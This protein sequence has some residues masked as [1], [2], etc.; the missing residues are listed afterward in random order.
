MQ[1]SY[2]KKGTLGAW[3]LPN[4]EMSLGSDCASPFELQLP[5]GREAFDPVASL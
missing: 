4:E 2:A 5:T 3:S 1:A